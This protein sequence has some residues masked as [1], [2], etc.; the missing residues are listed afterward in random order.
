MGQSYFPGR[1]RIV[2][3]W[4]ACG[5]WFGR[6]GKRL[7]AVAAAVLLSVLVPASPALSHPQLVVTTPAAGEH[8]VRAPGEITLRFSEQVRPVR[9]AVRVLDSTGRDV[10]RAQPQVPAGK[11]DEVSLALPANLP[12]GGYL[13]TWRVVSVD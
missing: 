12:D 1:L 4:P 9:G 3:V 13:V 2:G 10:A 5:R 11:P 8:L 7:A 6:T